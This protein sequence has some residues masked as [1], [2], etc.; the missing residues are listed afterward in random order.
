MLWLRNYTS[1]P[2]GQFYYK[3]A[4]AGDHLFGP[5]PI[6]G[7]VAEEVSAFRRGNGLP[8]SAAT[9]CFEDVIRFT[10]ARLDP[11]SEWIIDTDLSVNTL[12]VPPSAGCGSCGAVVT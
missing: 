3:Q 9:E 10:V 2:P 6:I 5:S 7:T 11:R 1:C 12:V 4:E 8:R